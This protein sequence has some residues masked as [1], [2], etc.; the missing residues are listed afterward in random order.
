MIEAPVGRPSPGWFVESLG[1]GVQQLNVYPI[2]QLGMWL[3]ACYILAQRPLKEWIFFANSAKQTLALLLEEESLRDVEQS[4]EH[5]QHMSALLTMF[6]GMHKL[7]GETTLTEENVLKFNR[8]F[9]ELDRALAVELGRAPIFFVTRTGAYDTRTLIAGASATYD[10]YDWNIPLATR[11]D[12][13]EAGR[14]MAFSLPTA[15]GF[16]I[17]RATETVIKLYMTTYGC[18]APKE[19]QRNWAHYVDALKTA[20]APETICNQL[21]QLRIL[22]RNPL[23]H[24]DQTLEMADARVLWA[25]CESL[26]LTMARD[27]GNRANRSPVA[28]P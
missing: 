16:H 19:S 8:V 7:N 24:P 21:H 9:S 14:C 23:S 28:S 2:Y 6:I 18:A 17:A 5:S 27:M 1:G 10:D 22:H 12:T 3:E 25:M 13:D 4:R 20:G 15:A 11:M 26:I